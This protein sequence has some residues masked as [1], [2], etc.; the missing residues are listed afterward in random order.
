MMICRADFEELFPDIFKPVE[1]VPSQ[2]EAGGD[3]RSALQEQRPLLIGE[4]RPPRHLAAGS[5][6]VVKISPPRAHQPG[7]GLA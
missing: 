7:Q 4:G 5:A 6:K 2:C 1:A 3:A